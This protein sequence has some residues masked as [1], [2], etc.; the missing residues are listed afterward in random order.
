MGHICMLTNLAYSSV[1]WV[2][3]RAV[4][5]SVKVDFTTPFCSDETTEGAARSC[6]KKE[7]T[8]TGGGGGGGR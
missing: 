1:Y 6:K 4:T 3:I 8:G 7:A 5:S 2:E